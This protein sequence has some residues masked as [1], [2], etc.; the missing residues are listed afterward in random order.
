MK[1]KEIFSYQPE[2]RQN[3][4]TLPTDRQFQYAIRVTGVPKRELRSI[5]QW[6]DPM[7]IM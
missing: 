2:Q 7:K 6:Q 5:L 4:F 3:I 1:E